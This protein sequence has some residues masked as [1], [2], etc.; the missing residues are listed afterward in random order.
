MHLT[1]IFASCAMSVSCL[2]PTAAKAHFPWIVPEADRKIS[3]HFGE[4][5][6]D[7]TYHLPSAMLKAPVLHMTGPGE[8]LVLKMIQLEEEAFVGLRSETP[9]PNDSLV[10]TQITYGVYHGALLNYYA[11]HY[12]GKLPASRDA[13]KSLTSGLDL[14]VEIVA[15]E[16]GVDVYATWQGQPLAGAE[17]HL[18]DAQGDAN[19]TTTTN[20]EGHGSFT[21][22]QI[23]SGLN[24]IMVGHKLELSGQVEATA[25]TSQSHYLTMTFLAPH[26]KP[27]ATLAMTQARPLPDLPRELTSFGAAK[28]GDA[29]YVYGG[30]TGSAHS[31]S[32]EEQSNQLLRLDLANLQAG[33][34]VVSSGPRLQGLAMIAHEKRLVMLGGFTA[35]NAAGEEQDLHSQASV[36]TFDTASN[37]WSELASLPE[38]RSSHDAAVIGDTVY[39]VGGW[40]LQT[41]EE[42]VWHTT[43]WSINLDEAEPQ[44]L[45]I[46][47]PPFTRRALAVIASE[48][49]LFV[50]GGM[51]QAGGP[52]RA[53]SIYDPATNAWSSAPA[54]RGKSDMAGFGVAGWTTPA[55]VV[56]TTYEGDIQRLGKSQEGWELLGKSKTARFFHRLLPLTAFELVAVG[57][58]NMEEGKYLELETIEVR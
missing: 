45:P 34:Q 35:N 30:H 57:G 39:V 28:I 17:V 2:L 58:A 32:T 15:T 4:G 11:L 42:T 43:A 52:T 16:L 38:P 27:K 8:P 47:T 31:Y 46:A 1:R 44:W 23:E 56:V 14:N 20:S 21:D 7:R 37:T 33:W 19:G 53:V 48:D 29:L 3:I 54:L 5:L 10:A 55:G 18:Y 13:Y 25:Y 26:S 51:N 24:A 12:G 9:L 22:A 36:L 50:V 41:G 49:K 40:N 6:A